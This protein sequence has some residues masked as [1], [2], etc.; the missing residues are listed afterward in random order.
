MRFQ[1]FSLSVCSVLQPPSVTSQLSRAHHTTSGFGTGLK[2]DRCV[3]GLID[4]MVRGIG[5]TYGHADSYCDSITLL[6][7]NLPDTLVRRRCNGEAPRE[8][9][10]N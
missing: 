8:Q 4:L 9:M 7:V 5:P 3:T 2:C 6:P 10:H 1:L